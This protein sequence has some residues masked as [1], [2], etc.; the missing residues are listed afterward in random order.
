MTV[1]LR[2]RRVHAR[3]PGSDRD[4][5]RDVS[6][7]VTQGEVLAVVGPNG[8]GKSTLLAV[9]GAEIRPRSGGVEVGDRDLFKMSRRSRARVISRL[10]QDPIPPE[11]LT[12]EALVACGRHPHRPA[13]VSL[14]P[15]DERAISKALDVVSLADFRRRKVETLSGGERRRAWIAMVLAQETDILLLD[16][17]T[18]ALDLRHQWELLELLERLNQELGTTI[19]VSLHDLDQAARL[20]DRVAI[21]HNGRLYACDESRRVIEEEM[22]R[23]VFRVDTQIIQEQSATR[24]QVLG[25]ADPVRS[26]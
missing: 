23:D 2:A 17:P 18:A 4:A 14:S 25:P 6:L 10:P 13:F 11:G 26:L 5:L 1:A 15:E 19:V 12:V 22:L 16:E 20:A 8:S 21:M 3:H 24:V 9:L 7:G